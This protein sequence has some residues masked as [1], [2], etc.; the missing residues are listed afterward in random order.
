MPIVDTVIEAQSGEVALQRL[1][2]DVVQTGKQ[3][4]GEYDGA[5]ANLVVT[6]VVGEKEQLVLLDGSA[7][8]EAVLP[9][10][11]EGIRIEGIAPQRRIGGHIVIAEEKEAAA[12]KLVG[13]RAGDDVD[14]AG[15][16]GSRGKVEVEGADLEFLDG[17]RR[18]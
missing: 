3:W 5:G 7:D 18:K 4:I 16:D 12:V 14:G 1:L 6:L 9:A 15:R 17:F 11:K 8:A 13:A 10:H 2:R